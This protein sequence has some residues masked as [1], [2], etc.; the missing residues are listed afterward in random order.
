[1]TLLTPSNNHSAPTKYT[2]KNRVSPSQPNQ[3][4]K[5]IFLKVQLTNITA[6]IK[7]PSFAECI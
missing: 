4:K 6:D 3:L 1:M 5:T 2:Y 7:A